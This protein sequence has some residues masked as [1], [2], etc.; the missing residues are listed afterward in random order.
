MAGLSLAG[1]Q[2][3]VILEGAV[4]TDVFE[5]YVE[6]VLVPTLPPGSVVVLDNLS[7]HPGTWVRQTIEARGCQMLFLPAYS[8]DLT[9]IEEAFSKLKAFL[10]R[11]GAR[12]RE[13]LGRGYRSGPED[14]H[15]TRG[16]GLVWALRLS[17]QNRPWLRS[18]NQGSTFMYPAVDEQQAQVRE[19][20]RVPAASLPLL[21]RISRLPERLVALQGG[22]RGWSHTNEPPLQVLP[23]SQC[24][25]SEVKQATDSRPVVFD[26][27]ALP[28]ILQIRFWWH[29]NLRCYKG[30]DHPRDFVLKGREAPFPLKI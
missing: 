20:Q 8:P 23:I 24:R 17:S 4:D 15:Q 29:A 30:E 5:R 3:P 19:V 1:I 14:N 26:T 9:P 2:A 12:T 18:Y 22:E 13:A 16:S 25:F 6:H 11:M 7:V 28:I 10:R 21:A 27:P